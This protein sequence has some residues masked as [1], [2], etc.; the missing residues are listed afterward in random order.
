MT[1]ALAEHARPT[2]PGPLVDPTGGDLVRLPL[3]ELHP[4]LANRKRMQE[5]ALQELADN[6]TAVGQLEPAL[7]RPRAKGGYEIVSGERRWRAAKLAGLP[8][9]L[10]LRR[11]LTD[12]QAIVVIATANDQRENPDP[13]DEA[14]LYKQMLLFKGWTPARIAKQLGRGETYVRDR[15]RL[16]RLTPASRQLVIDD[17]ITL[18]HAILLASLNLEQQKNAITQSSGGAGVGGLFRDE[19]TL[20]SHSKRDGV[21]VSVEEFRDWIR[22]QV[23]LDPRAEVTGELWP[24]TAA[25]VQEADAVRQK[26]LLLTTEYQA[27]QAVR[28]GVDRVFGQPSWKRADGSKGAKTCEYSK[29]GVLVSG[30]H[31][32]DAF[33][34]CVRRDKC[35]THW[36]QS[37]KAAAKRAKAREQGARGG[38]ATGSTK[39]GATTP[40]KAEAKAAAE[41]AA[42]EAELARWQQAYPEILKSVLATVKSL[43]AGADSKIGKALLQRLY[44]DPGVNKLI[45]PGKTAEDLVRYLYV[46][47]LYDNEDLGEGF[48]E[49]SSGRFQNL[50]KELGVHAQKIVDRVAPAPKAEPPAKAKAK[51]TKKRA[52]DVRRAKAK[53]KAG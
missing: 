38:T 20:F 16:L 43:P 50:C 47:D 32:G 39:A 29:L 14:E 53:Q 2:G 31:Q 9:L 15:L 1:T 21:P 41:L 46:G 10:C 4:H 45:T 18:Q 22:R 42:K 28:H 23:R 24:E 6:L 44:V 33:Q 8:D 52:G 25:A 17:E 12:E 34:A 19:Q 48:D 49:Y 11:A 35:L 3:A 51:G 7:V 36:P 37:A 27:S 13:I 30:E 26:V 40:S 5:A